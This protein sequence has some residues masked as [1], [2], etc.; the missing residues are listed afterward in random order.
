MASEQRFYV[1][2]LRGRRPLGKCEW[3]PECH[4]Y[5]LSTVT[6]RWHCLLLPLVVPIAVWD[7]LA[8]GRHTQRSGLSYM[9][10]RH[11]NHRNGNGYANAGS[12]AG[13]QYGGADLAC[14]SDI[15]PVSGPH[16]R[17]RAPRARGLAVR[18]PGAR[19]RRFVRRF[20]RS[21]LREATTPDR[22]WCTLPRT[23]GLM[24]MYYYVRSAPP[25][26]IFLNLKICWFHIPPND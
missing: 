5:G 20:L 19:A 13:T 6:Y 12:R 3:H 1:V 2:P 10:H 9:F 16:F 11:R 14:D 17:W 18:D 24:T 22:H 21:L 23:A 26:W 25:H 8:N 7:D 15:L 4:E